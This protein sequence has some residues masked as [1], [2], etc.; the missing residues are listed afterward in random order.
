MGE[1][2]MPSE[3]LD[4]E[5]DTIYLKTSK[6]SNRLVKMVSLMDLVI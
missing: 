2:K 4:K 1:I 3:I 5:D 6:G